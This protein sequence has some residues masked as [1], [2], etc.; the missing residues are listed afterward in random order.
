MYARKGPLIFIGASTEALLGC[1]PLSRY[2]NK[3]HIAAGARSLSM[4]VESKE[5]WVLPRSGELP[6]LQLKVVASSAASG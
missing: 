6:G 2:P 5:R 3:S 4:V 1:P